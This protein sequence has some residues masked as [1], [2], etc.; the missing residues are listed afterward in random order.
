MSAPPPLRPPGAIAEDQFTDGC[1]ACGECIEVCPQTI[2][3]RGSGGFPE[4]DFTRAECT[5]CGDCIAVCPE[6]VLRPGVE[7]PWT[8]TIRV[9]DTCLARRQVVCQSCGDVCDAGAIGFRPRLG[10]VAVP[11]IDADSCIGCGACVAA[12]P[13]HALEAVAGG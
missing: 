9:L 1:T 2:V 7:P 13:E 5:F 4:I 3:V 8:V 12:C 11:G 10:E 6:G